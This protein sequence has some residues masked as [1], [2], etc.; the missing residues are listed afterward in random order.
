MFVF[1]G[2]YVLVFVVVGVVCLVCCLFVGALLA[3]FVLWVLVAVICLLCV[4]F[5]V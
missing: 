2:C 5:V 4:P 3:C 1:S